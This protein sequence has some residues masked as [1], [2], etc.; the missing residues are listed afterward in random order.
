MGNKANAAIPVYGN[1]VVTAA[2]DLP[3]STDGALFTVSGGPVIVTAI[4]GEVTTVI[5]TQAN[6]MKLK[7]NPDA[8]GADQ[9]LCAVLN[10]SA[11]AVGTIYTITGTVGDAMVDDLLI[12]NP[13]LAAPLFLSEGSIEL[14]CA[15]S[16]TGQVKWGLL[17]VPAEAGGTITAA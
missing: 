5:Q 15:A 1:R 14:D 3:Q 4:W 13:A 12:G 16:N 17:Y 11:D 2:A 6:N 10:V 7:F 9:D 8:T